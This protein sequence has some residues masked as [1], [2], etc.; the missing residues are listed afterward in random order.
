[1]MIEILRSGGRA[2]ATVGLGAALLA[3]SIAL[4]AGTLSIDRMAEANQR[5]GQLR[6]PAGATTRAAAATVGHRPADASRGPDEDDLRTIER[7]LA[8]LRAIE[9]G[10]LAAGLAIA[11]AAAWRVVRAA[12]WPVLAITDVLPLRR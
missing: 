5:L 11:A 10:L 6:A 9:R 1:M 12:I 8:R 2:R 4:A 7:E 3:L